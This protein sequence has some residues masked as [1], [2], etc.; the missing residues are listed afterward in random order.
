MNAQT[1]SDFLIQQGELLEESTVSQLRIIEQESE[2]TTYT[3]NLKNFLE[4]N[5]PDINFSGLYQQLFPQQEKG[6]IRIVKSYEKSP[7]KKTVQDFSNYFL[8]RFKNAEK[9][10]RSRSELSGLL[11]INRLQGRKEQSVAIIGMINEISETKN[12]HIIL[13]VEDPTGLTKVLIHKDNTELIEVAKDL[14]LDEIIGITGTAGDKIVFCNSVVF[15]D[16]PLSKELKKSPYDHYAVFS[17]DQQFGHKLF[18]EKEFK[19]FLLWLNGKVGSLEQREI[20]KKVKYFF[21]IGDL[22]EGVGIYPGQE[23]DIDI[24]CKEQYKLAT[25]YLKKIPSHIKIIICAG[26]HDVGRIAEPQFPIPKEWAPELYDMPNVIMVS[27]PCYISLDVTDEF[28]GID[29]L[30]YHGGSLPYY[31]N[32]LSSIRSRGGLKLSDEIMVALLKRRHLAPSHGS[33]LYV[34]DK[35]EDPLFIDKIPDIFLTGHIHRAQTINYRNITCINS[36]AWSGVTEDQLKRGLD[37][38]PGRAFVVSLKTRQIK[39]MNFMSK[40]K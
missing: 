25:S 22:I 30:M 16:I 34:P 14:M 20:A 4:R 2:P 18:L 35:Y 19:K 37:P 24:L 21:I 13:E 7:T 23:H 5:F 32:M 10:L 17:G 36:S 40:E 39:L 38:Q 9:L 3:T 1:I 11:S 8:L 33:T 31:A 6:R 26:N 12:K 28:S 15:P 27:N 29:V